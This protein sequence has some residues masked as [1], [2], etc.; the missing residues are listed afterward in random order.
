MTIPSDS[1]LWS[2][3]FCTGTVTGRLAGFIPQ[4]M[5]DRNWRFAIIQ[6]SIS[7]LFEFSKKSV[8]EVL[9]RQTIYLEGAANTYQYSKPVYI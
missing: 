9:L 1:L 5:W 3:A 6:Y 8:S 4:E 2:A 7:V